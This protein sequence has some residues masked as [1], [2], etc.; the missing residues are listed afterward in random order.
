[1]LKN[2]LKSPPN[3][4]LF[5]AF[6]PPTPMNLALNQS[7][8]FASEPSRADAFIDVHHH[9]NPTFRDNEGNPWSIEM[10]LAELDQNGITAAIASMGPFRDPSLKER[11]WQIREWNEWAGKLCLDH[12]GRFGLFASLPVSHID[13]AVVEIAHVY[14]VLHVDG[15]NLTTNDGDVWLSDERYWPIFEELNRR[16][17][18][19]FVHPAPTSL[20]ESICQAYGSDLVSPAW[21]EFPMNTTRAILGLLTKGVTRSFPNIRFIFCHGG[22][23][24]PLMLGRIVGFSGW[25][26]VG[27]DKLAALFP[28][29][30]YEEFGK[31]Y[32]DCAQAYA[33]ETID[34]LQRMVPNSHLLFGSDYSYFP[35]A[36][37]IEQFSALCL[38]KDI[39][40][41]IRSGNSAALFPRFS[42]VK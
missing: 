11:P 10:A 20:C 6:F 29:G 12:P 35:V 2:W 13:L 3:Q 28:D 25:K 16:N 8:G 27:P 31:L 42:K 5:E 17:A 40:T 33:P 14:D 22:G 21:L 4:K 34:L 24:M 15:I 9:F 23:A 26:T 18:A 1:L 7:T 32:F 19:V 41:A 36:H 38:N 39:R 30:L 37:S